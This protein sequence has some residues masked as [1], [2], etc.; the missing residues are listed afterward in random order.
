[1]GFGS[2]RRRCRAETLARGRG[3]A[4]SGTGIEGFGSG[5]SQKGSG[6]RGS[7]RSSNG[8]VFETPQ[9]FRVGREQG[10]LDCPE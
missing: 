9:V 8:A 10:E 5:V 4:V 7:S 3:A 1:M 6:K 2:Q